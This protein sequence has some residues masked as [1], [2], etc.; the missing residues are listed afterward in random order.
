MTKEMLV[1]FRT[2]AEFEHMT[3][4]ADKL[5]ITQSAL[6]KTIRALE[7][8][9]EVDLFQRRGRNVVL[10]AAGEA[11]YKHVVRALDE[12]DEGIA[13]AKRHME[14]ESNIIHLSVLFTQFASQL[15]EK[16]LAFHRGYP[17]CHFSVEYK[18]TS[19]V[20]EDLL[21]GSSELGV[22]GYVPDTGNYA[23]IEK[24]LIQRE[25]ASII[26]GK[27]HRLAKRS[28]V[29]ADDIRDEKFV[30]WKWSEL[31]INQEIKKIGEKCGFTPRIGYEGHNDLAVLNAVAVGEGIAVV[32]VG[33]TLD[34]SQV[35]PVKLE[36]DSPLT[37]EVYLAWRKDIKL[38]ALAVQFRNMLL[39]RT[40]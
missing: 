23:K 30:V 39:S 10:T 37:W 29:T 24:K 6:S 11:F 13:E 19:A 36:M 8:E 15:P 38:S 14:V 5:Y 16:I 4:A 31:G 27:N 35:V 26:V 1:Y 21:S 33:G 2:A 9:M 18:Y 20:V 3:K 32:P 40:K 12:L 22:C 7:E 28:T 25:P 17:L 34:L